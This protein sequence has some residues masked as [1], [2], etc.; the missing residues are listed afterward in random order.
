MVIRPHAEH[1]SLTFRATYILARHTALVWYQGFALGAD[2]I[3]T[4]T[5]GV[6][7]LMSGHDL[8]F[9]MNKYLPFRL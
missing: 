8:N 7:L 1:F 4:T 9:L 2:T 6:L 3:T 5:H